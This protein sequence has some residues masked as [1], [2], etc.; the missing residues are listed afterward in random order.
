MSDETDDFKTMPE[1]SCAGD[2]RA[3][4]SWTGKD[5]RAFFMEEGDHA[6]TSD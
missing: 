5:L 3:V 4:H 2:G 1:D 6:N